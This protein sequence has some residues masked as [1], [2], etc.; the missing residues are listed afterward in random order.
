MGERYIHEQYRS[1]SIII[2][3]K[4]ATEKILKNTSFFET[5]FEMTSKKI[6]TPIS[7][8]N[9]VQKAQQE[10]LREKVK[11]LEN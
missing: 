2:I 4:K 6:S 8:D 1:N 10:D 3:I 5:F 7:S 9:D 11:E